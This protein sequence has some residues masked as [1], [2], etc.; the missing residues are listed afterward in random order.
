MSF[1]QATVMRDFVC[2]VKDRDNI[3]MVLIGNKCD[4]EHAKLENL[5]QDAELLTLCLQHK[6]HLYFAETSAKQLT[7]V[8]ALFMRIA[9]LLGMQTQTPPVHLAHELFLTG[10]SEKTASVVTAM[11]TS[12]STQKP[13]SRCKC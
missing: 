3:P 4:L 7:T 8:E 5:E 13:Q 10:P 11:S 2:R 12:N 9:L 1:E 6:C